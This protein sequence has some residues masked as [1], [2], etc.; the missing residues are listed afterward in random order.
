MADAF[1]ERPILN[2]P[3]RYPGRHWELDGDG[4]PTNRILDIRRRSELVTPV[5]KPKKRKKSANQ[6]SM[7]F[8]AGDDLSSQEQEYNPTPIINEIRTY[9]ETWRNLQNPEQWLVTPETARLLR[10]WRSTTSGR[11]AV[12]L[13]DRGG[14]DG[15]L[16]DRGRPENGAALR[17][18]SGTTSRT[19]TRRRTPSSSASR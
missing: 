4:Q 9:V 16:A 2:S 19:P 17:Q 1:F 12:L 3:Y 7:A 11:A 13:P 10:H 5:P 18:N 14:R 15:D 8:D 6:M